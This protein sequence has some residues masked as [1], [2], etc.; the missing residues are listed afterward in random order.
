MEELLTIDFKSIVR[1]LLR[2]QPHLAAWTDVCEIYIDKFDNHFST[3]LII[4]CQ[5]EALASF[6]IQNVNALL[7]PIADT[8]PIPVRIIHEDSLIAAYLPL[9][10]LSPNEGVTGLIMVTTTLQ[11]AQTNN[12]QAIAESIGLNQIPTSMQ[13]LVIEQVASLGLPVTLDN[14]GGYKLPQTTFNIAWQEIGNAVWRQ[15]FGAIAEPAPITDNGAKAA[16][17][18]TAPT[19]PAEK[20]ATQKSETPR[21]LLMREKLKPEEDINLGRNGVKLTLD[22]FLAKVST[23]HYD[24][25]QILD[26]MINQ[27][28]HGLKL[29]EKLYE[30]YAKRDGIYKVRPQE[31]AKTKAKIIDECRKLLNPPAQ[32]QVL[33]TE[34]QQ[35]AETTTE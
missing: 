10:E 4:D 11:Q 13:D 19:K 7:G 35:E 26:F 30:A 25:D 20:R 14:K 29:L 1:R 22:N 17:K 27:T 8:S 3:C 23:K 2:N 12:Q 24:R 33:E 18:P 5:F 15:E 16:A 34:A 6:F 28:E 9:L 21:A 31:W 32:E